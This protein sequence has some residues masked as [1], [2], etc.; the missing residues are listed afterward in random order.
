MAPSSQSLEPPQYPGR[1]TKAMPNG[2]CK[3][4]GGM[5]T[6]P[7]TLEGRQAI[8]RATRKRMASGQQERALEG[9]YSWLEAGGVGKSFRSLPRTVRSESDGRGWCLSKYTHRARVHDRDMGCLGYRIKK[10]IIN[11]ISRRECC[12]CLLI[13]EIFQSRS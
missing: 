11:F 5:S 9:F 2:R 12:V 7:Q 4:H 10:L 6:A 13:C 8:A 3:N 1:F